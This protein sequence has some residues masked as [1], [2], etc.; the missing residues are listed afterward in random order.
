[1]A[2]F[3]MPFNSFG[4]AVKCD[5]QVR[6]TINI[7]CQQ[8]ETVHISPPWLLQVTHAG[9]IGVDFLCL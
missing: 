5:T 9:M 2:L 4:G 3:L 1:M 8:G 7:I 6:F